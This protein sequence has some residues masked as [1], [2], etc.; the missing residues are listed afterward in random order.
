MH[1]SIT[2][3]HNV[4]GKYLEIIGILRSLP[5]LNSKKAVTNL[6]TERANKLFDEIYE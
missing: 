5:F 3:I 1:N 6:V 2:F 4:K